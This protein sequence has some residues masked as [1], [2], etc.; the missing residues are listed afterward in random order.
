MLKNHSIIPDIKTIIETS[1][2]RAIRAVDNE[3]TMMY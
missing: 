3:R 1:K 2:E